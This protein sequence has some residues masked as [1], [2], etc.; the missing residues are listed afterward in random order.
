[1]ASV[2]YRAMSQC[3]WNEWRKV[4][5]IVSFWLE[6]MS[7]KLGFFFRSLFPWPRSACECCCCCRWTVGG[8]AARSFHNSPIFQ[9]ISSVCHS[10]A[11][12][13]KQRRTLAGQ[14]DCVC[15]CCVFIRMFVCD[16]CTKQPKFRVSCVCVRVSE[17]MKRR[18]YLNVNRT[19]SG[20]D[21]IVFSVIQNE[22]NYIFRTLR[23]LVGR[24]TC[25]QANT[26]IK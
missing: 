16:L 17:R 25:T 24:T 9:H 18:K 12:T 11:H 10:V 7:T 6:L 4:R 22:S 19:Y 2:P 3:Q 15:V 26:D 20:F 8:L 1:M 21:G 13:R 14:I 5:K 23:L